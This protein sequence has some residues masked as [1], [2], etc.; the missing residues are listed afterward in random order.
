[1]KVILSTLNAIF[2]F[3]FQLKQLKMT[4]RPSQ[5]QP[6]AKE[7]EEEENIWRRKIFD[8]RRR[9]KTEKEKGED[10]WRRKTFGPQKRRK[11]TKKE[12]EENIWSGKLVECRS[13]NTIERWR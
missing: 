6:V 9:R 7:K 11:Q 3:S 13:K 10:I 8:P 4:G 1:M 2:H 5:T 12:K